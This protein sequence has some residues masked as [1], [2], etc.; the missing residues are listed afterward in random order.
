MEGLAIPAGQLLPDGM[1][2][3]SPKLKPEPYDP[4]GAKKLLAEAGYPDGFGL[5]IHAPNNRY[6][7]DEQIAQAVA[8]MLTRVGILTKVEA[9]P[10][11]IFFTRG[12]KLDFSFLLVGWGA[13]TGEVS[14]PL[15]SLLATYHKDKGMGAANRGRYSNPKMDQVLEL[16][17]ATVDDAKREAL[18]QQAVEISMNDV[19]V[20]PTH[21]QVNTWAARKGI[22]YTARTDERTHAFAFVPGK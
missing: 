5:T 13:D 7:N 10:A 18:L 19:G 11:N 17:L 14:S 2:G 20:I 15:K 22:T 4:D 21:F 1:F 8:Q 3:V 12:S 9:M 6:V 16:A